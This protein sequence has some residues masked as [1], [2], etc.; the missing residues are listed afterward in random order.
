M[1][2]LI[3]AVVAAL[4]AAP[5]THAQ[6]WDTIASFGGAWDTNWGDTWVLT[7]GPGYIGTYTDD[8]GRFWL[9]FT[10]H[11]FEGYWA[12]DSSDYRCDY[13]VMG[14]YYWGRLELANSSRFP[15]IQMAWGYCDWGN[16]DKAWTFR[17]RLPDGM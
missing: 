3:P 10:D 15:G 13:P 2:H 16:L 7:G 12:E 5:A 11:V 6:Q 17:E 1:K 9:Q 4:L 14:S 8:N